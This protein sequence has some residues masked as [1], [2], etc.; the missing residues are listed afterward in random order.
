[1]PGYTLLRYAHAEKTNAL[2]AL[3]REWFIQAPDDAGA[4]SLAR[5]LLADFQPGG[6]RAVLLN[7]NGKMV[8]ES[9]PGHPGL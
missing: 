3:A 8:W 7:Q 1:M 6:E 4:L 2:A 5:K 9:G